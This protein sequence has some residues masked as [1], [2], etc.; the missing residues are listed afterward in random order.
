MWGSKNKNACFYA[1]KN[2]FKRYFT[3]LFWLKG[4][5]YDIMPYF[6]YITIH[7]S[8]STLPTVADDCSD[9]RLC[10]F[11]KHGNRSKRRDLRQR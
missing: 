9:S 4:K 3:I 10:L 5:N 2:V 7:S 11:T 1:F 6:P 8:P